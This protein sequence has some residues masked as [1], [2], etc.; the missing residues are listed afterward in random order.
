MKLPYVWLKEFIDLELSAQETANLLTLLGLEVEAQEEIAGTPVFDIKVTPNRGDC[1]SAVG[2]ARELSAALQLPLHP[3]Q[4]A[5]PESGIPAAEAATVTIDAP[6]LCPRYS[7]RIFRNIKLGTSPDWLRYRLEQCGIRP[8]NNVVDITNLVM[9]ETGQPL[10]AFDADLVHAVPGGKV[11]AIIVRRAQPGEKMMTLDGEARALT[12]DMLVI[13]DGTRAVALAGVMGG[14]NTEVNDRTVTVLL[15]SAHFNPLCIRRASKALGMTSEASYRME[16]RVDPGGTVVALDRAATLLAELAGAE[17][18]PGVIDAQPAPIA[19]PP[20]RIRVAKVNILLGTMLSAQEMAVYLKRLFI[21]V[22][23]KDDV[24]IVQPPSFRGDLVL[25]EDIAEEI[26]RL[27]GYDQVPSQYLSAGASGGRVAPSLALDMQARRALLAC[28]LNETVNYSLQAPGEMEK[29]G[30]PADDPLARTVI[31]RNPKAEDYSQLRTSMIT[32]M[33]DLLNRNWRRGLREVQAFE[34]GRIYLPKAG[35]E[36]PEERHA[37]G[38]ALLAGP[39]PTGWGHTRPDFYNLKGIVEALF[40]ALDVQDLTFTPVEHPSLA[41]GQAAQVATG[42]IRLGVLGAVRDTVLA[43]YD[44][45]KETFIAELDLEALL[46]MPR[47]PAAYQPISRFPAVERDLALLVP[48]NCPAEKVLEVLRAQGGEFLEQVALFDV[49]EG[50]S[51]PAGTRS[52]A[53]ALTFR[54]MDRTLTEAEVE[55]VIANIKTALGALSVQIRQ[56]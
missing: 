2:I 53:Y 39:H 54:A 16:R 13:A 18:A 40:T 52:L 43:N 27:H 3:P 49:Y 19:M 4:I 22:E 35:E 44:L 42:A 50:K 55:A 28:G 15:E 51:L 31:I 45:P 9:M 30:F 17:V 6:D 25:E 5:F 33:L 38:I 1:L 14:A 48:H 41:P 11:P 23:I 8:I 20:V 24:L 37:I 32:S 47:P 36:L 46:Q 29:A 56:Q 34:L 12:T 21:E 10:H 26:A 7:A